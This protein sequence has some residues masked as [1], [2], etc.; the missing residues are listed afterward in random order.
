[1]PILRKSLLFILI[2]VLLYGVLL[3]GE[4]LTR[5]EL[6]RVAHASN[7]EAVC[8]LWQPRF[9]RGGGVCSLQLLNARGEVVDAAPL[10]TLKTGFDALQQF[11]Q[12]GYQE[13]DVTVANLQTGELVRRF[14]VRDGR[15][16]EESKVER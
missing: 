10:G 14:V 12:L 8:L 13:G 2:A 16:K 1:M 6:T 4:R 7:G 11:G 3:L 5:Q 9:L 15:L